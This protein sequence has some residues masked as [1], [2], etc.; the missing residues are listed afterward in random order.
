M[1]RWWRLRKKKS[2]V[3]PKHK[4]SVKSCQNSCD[5]FL[6]AAAACSSGSLTL[7]ASIAALLNQLNKQCKECC[8]GKGFFE[9]CIKPLQK[10]IQQPT[11][12]A[13]PD[14]YDDMNNRN[15]NTGQWAQDH[16]NKTNKFWEQR[17]RNGGFSR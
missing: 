7:K 5:I 11:D 8:K 4:K 13:F 10:Y 12:P 16:Y 6:S 14:H 2:Q 15:Q 17:Y 3:T 9:N 1:R